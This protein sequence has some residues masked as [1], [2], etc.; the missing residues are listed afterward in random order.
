MSNIVSVDGNG[1][2]IYYGLLSSKEKATVD[3]IL[4]TIKEEIPQIET[5]LN[6]EFGNSILY[7][8]NLGLYLGELL[9]KYNI[10]VYERRKFWDEIKNL[11]SKEDRKRDEGKNS[12]R[13]SFYQQC[14][15]LS[16]LGK[17]TVNKMSWRQW[18]SIL[19]RDRDREDERIFE[20]IKQYPEK[21]REDDWREF[22][23][24]LHLFLKNKDTS[25]FETGELFAIYDSLMLMAQAWRVKI[26]DFEETNPKSLKL[27]NKSKWSKKYY[28]K[29][30]MIKKE[31][32]SRIITN[33]I[34][35]MAFNQVM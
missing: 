2:L 5:E 18:Q 32:K 6:E 30:F 34:C 13:R 28:S 21:I 9:Y 25:V 35:D 15:E 20:W 17:E 12:A 11:A 31:K 22:Q 29:C 4:E 27:K 33:E 14:Y 1:N 7:K 24:G 10:P 26:K 3:E 16:C 19:D 23:K 8:Y